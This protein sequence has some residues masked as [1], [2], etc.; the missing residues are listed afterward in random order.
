MATVTENTVYFLPNSDAEQAQ[1]Y[2]FMPMEKFDKKDDVIRDAFN[3]YFS[4]GFNGLVLDEI[5]GKRSMAYSAGA[6]IGTPSLPG[7]RLI[8]SVTSVRRMIKPTMH[9]MYSWV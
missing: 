7:T 6:Y 5:R 9:W 2:F 4:G 3:Q 1:I 8:C